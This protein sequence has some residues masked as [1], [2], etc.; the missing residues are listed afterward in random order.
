MRQLGECCNVGLDTLVNVVA[1]D[2]VILV[3]G[4]VALDWT[5]CP[6]ERCQDVE[7]ECCSC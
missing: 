3:N 4:D 1:L 2:K 7:V 5:A 6:D